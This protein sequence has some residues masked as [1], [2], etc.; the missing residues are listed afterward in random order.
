MTYSLRFL[1]EVEEDVM[2]GYVWYEKKS[3]GLGEDFL[4]MFYACDIEISRNPLMYPKVY[5]EFRRRLLRKFPYAVYFITENDEIIVVGLFHCA[6]DPR[7]IKTELEN[8]DET[9]RL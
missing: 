8:R 7:T 9:D 6:R 4:R 5:E 2:A 3:K 1:P